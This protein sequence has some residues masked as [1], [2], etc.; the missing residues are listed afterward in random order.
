MFHFLRTTERRGVSMGRNPAPVSVPVLWPC[1]SPIYF[2]KTTKDSNGSFKKDRNT[3]SNLFGQHVDYWQNKG[4]DYSS[5]RYS[6]SLTS[7]S[8]ICYKLEKVSDDTSSGDRISENDSQFKRNEYFPS[9][10]K[11]QSIKQMCQDI[12]QNLETTVLELTKV[13]DHLTSTTWSSH[14]KTPLSFSP[15]ATNSGTEEK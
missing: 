8:G 13:L 5:T 1:T 4:R 11:L 3:H 7:V 15:T 12:N 14:S 9:T 6:H 10:K 2:H